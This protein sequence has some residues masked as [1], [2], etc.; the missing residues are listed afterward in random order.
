[1]L[2]FCFRMVFKNIISTAADHHTDSLLELI[3]K[4]YAIAGGARVQSDEIARHLLLYECTSFGSDMRKP[5][6]SLP[7]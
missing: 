3:P 4:S 1:M 5:D 7:N 2:R 6:Q